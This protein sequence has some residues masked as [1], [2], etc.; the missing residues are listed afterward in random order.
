MVW[1]LRVAAIVCPSAPH[2]DQVSRREKGH[3][4]LSDHDTPA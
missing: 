1:S 4:F 2:Q 3:L